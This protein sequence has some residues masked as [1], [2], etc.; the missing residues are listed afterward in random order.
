[1]LENLRNQQGL[2]DTGEDPEFA[3]AMGTGLDVDCKHPLEALHSQHW[4]RFLG[5]QCGLA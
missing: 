3:A 4:L 2:I 5:L 1:M